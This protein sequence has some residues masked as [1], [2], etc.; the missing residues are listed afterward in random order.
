MS[1]CVT[2]YILNTAQYT[3]LTILH[4]DRTIYKCAHE[5][6]LCVMNMTDIKRKVITSA[7]RAAVGP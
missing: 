6:T 3:S 7:Y 2:L 5:A 1:D 4:G